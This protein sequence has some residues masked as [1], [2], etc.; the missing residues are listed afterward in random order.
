MASK[1]TSHILVSIFLEDMCSYNL[2]WSYW[3]FIW[4]SGRES[5]VVGLAEESDFRKEYTILLN[6]TNPIHAQTILN[7]NG[8]Q[9]IHSITQTYDDHKWKKCHLEEFISDS[10]WPMHAKEEFVRLGRIAGTPGFALYLD[11]KGPN[12]IFE[13]NCQREAERIQALWEKSSMLI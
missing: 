1:G 5:F 4:K 6:V 12:A 13:P 7:W 9:K 3:L 2:H 11:N 10:Q 8:R